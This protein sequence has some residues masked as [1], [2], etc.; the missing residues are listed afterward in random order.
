MSNSLTHEQI[1]SAI[2][3][4]GYALKW[5]K[6][7]VTKQPDR[8]EIECNQGHRYHTTWKHFQRGNRCPQCV[9]QAPSTHEYV[10]AEIAKA[11]YVLRS[12]YNESNTQPGWGSI[13]TRIRGLFQGRR[14]A[15]TVQK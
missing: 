4:A 5:Y 12:S 2:A 1:E 8:V 10:A 6:I 14:A 11:G 15:Q 9:K 7:G 13:V 3:E